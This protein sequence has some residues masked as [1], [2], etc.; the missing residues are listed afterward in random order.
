M[1]PLMF[2]YMRVPDELSEEEARS[3]EA[4][5]KA[6][7]EKEGFTLA[8]IFQELH[9]F[10]FSAYE[11]L[12]NALQKAEARHVVVPSYDDLATSYHLQ[13]ALLRQV[14]HEAS[15]HVVSLDEL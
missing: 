4:A 1:R 15:A 11:E 2:G 14:R 3:R 5:M 12:M 8:S 6:Y 9:P 10:H 7:A 13:A